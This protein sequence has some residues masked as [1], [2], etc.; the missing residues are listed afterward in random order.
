MMLN[1]DRTAAAAASC[2][3]AVS[4]VVAAVAECAAQ[5]VAAEVT[6]GMVPGT[7]DASFDR[8]ARTR[9]WESLLD[10]GAWSICASAA[11]VQ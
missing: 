10:V 6:V 11:G 7:L 9:C 4:I 8:C 1:T 3:G 2:A 5:A